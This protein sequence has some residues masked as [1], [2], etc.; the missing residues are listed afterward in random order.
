MILSKRPGLISARSSTSILLVAA[1]TMTLLLRSKPSMQVSSMLSV[2][3]RSSLPWSP[4]R[5]R[6]TASISS[7][8]MM[9]GAAFL[10]CRQGA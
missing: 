1:I 9:A 5:S 4:P 3:S 8:K 10:A 2:V 7:M 6:P